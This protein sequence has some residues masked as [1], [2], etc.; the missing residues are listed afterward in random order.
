M[1]IGVAGEYCAGKSTVSRILTEYGFSEIDVDSYGHRALKTRKDAITAVFGAGILNEAG[2]I[3]RKSLGKIVFG[4]PEQKQQLE[5]IVHPAMTAEVI[6]DAERNQGDTVI[7]A[8][9][10]F[11]MGLHKVCD[12]VIWVS[13]PLL[14]RILRARRRDH[15]P[16]RE[17][18]KR[19]MSQKKLSSYIPLKNVDI[20]RVRSFGGERFLRSRI[21]SILRKHRGETI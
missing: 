17:I 19:I 2:E 10:L 20:E 21:K 3:D 8:A 7:N 15:L 12:L 6:K 18:W 5:K 9:V 14:I 16:L 13:A 11:Q 4:D 1:V